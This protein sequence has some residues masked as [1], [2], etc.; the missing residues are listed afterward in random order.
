MQSQTSEKPKPEIGDVAGF[1]FMVGVLAFVGLLVVVFGIDQ[2][3]DWFSGKNW[4]GPF[5][6]DEP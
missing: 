5:T 6:W 1:V 4:T 3:H 2:F